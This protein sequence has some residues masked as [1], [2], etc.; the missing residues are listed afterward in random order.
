[1]AKRLSHIITGA[2]PKQA[3]AVRKRK[4]K[5]AGIYLPLFIIDDV[6]TKNYS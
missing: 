4:A 2:V 1:L 5:A 3:G 6:D